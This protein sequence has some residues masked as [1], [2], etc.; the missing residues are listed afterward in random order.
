[1]Q[2]NEGRAGQVGS[3]QID[4]DDYSNIYSYPDKIQAVTADDVM[5]VAKQYLIENGRTVINLIPA[6]PAQ[7][8]AAPNKEEGK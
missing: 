1:L 7:A 4:T 3:F 5:R 8:A 2:S 6:Q